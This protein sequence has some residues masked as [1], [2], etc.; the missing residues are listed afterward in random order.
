MAKSK[1][2]LPRPGDVRGIHYFQS[3]WEI[4]EV[5]ETA[6]RRQAEAQKRVAEI[7]K[8]QPAFARG[9]LGL[10]EAELGLIRGEV[11]IRFLDNAKLSDS[12][13][14]R[15]EQCRENRIKNPTCSRD[16]A[17]RSVGLRAELLASL[18][19]HHY[20]R[21]VGK[22]SGDFAGLLTDAVIARQGRKDCSLKVRA[23][24]WAECLRFSVGLTV[25]ETAGTW[26]DNAWGNDPL[27]TPLSDLGMSENEAA[28]LKFRDSFRGIFEKQIQRDLSSWLYGADR[29]IELRLLLSPAP[30]RRAKMDASK[31][32]LALL[33]TASPAL[34]T[35]QVCSKLDAT[36][37]RSPRIAPIPSTWRARGA[38]SW[39]DAFDKFPGSVKTYVSTVRKQA[40]IA[41]AHSEGS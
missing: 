3:P 8:S 23:E 11:V 1:A 16:E 13:R 14:Q 30:Q 2:G 17:E 38:R 12:L 24:M 26:I 36:N 6:L 21:E 5:I 29:T 27:E 15:R 19:A 20:A 34:S 10:T 39:I 33:V 28:S 31:K 4:A 40:G 7:T 35:E 25:Y 22:A 41:K 9:S 18:F 32:A 37:E